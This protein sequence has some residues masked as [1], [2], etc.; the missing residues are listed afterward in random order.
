M[1]RWMV[2]RLMSKCMDVAMFLYEV[3]SFFVMRCVL[4]TDC[5]ITAVPPYQL[6]VMLINV[7]CY[8]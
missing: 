3:C 2:N 1:V 8:R 6:M 5:Y 4:S 7:N